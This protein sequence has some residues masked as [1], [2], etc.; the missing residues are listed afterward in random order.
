MTRIAKLLNTLLLLIFVAVNANGSSTL[1]VTAPGLE[2]LALEPAAQVG[3]ISWYDATKLFEPFL[4]RVEFI[5]EEGRLNFSDGQRWGAISG[6]APYTMVDGRPLEVKHPPIFFEGKLLVSEDF[7]RDTAQAIIQRELTTSIS[8]EERGLVVVIDPAYGGSSSGPKGYKPQEAKALTLSLARSLAERLGEGGYLVLLT[9][10]GDENKSALDRATIANRREA[11]LFLRIDLIGE[12]RREARG[13]EIFYPAPPKE[14]TSPNAWRGG[15]AA[16]YEQ[17]HLWAEILERALASSLAVMDRGILPV[18]S[19]LLSA[20][21]VPAATLYVGNISWPQE[22][23]LFTNEA[24]KK[25]LVETLFRAIDEY[26]SKG[27]E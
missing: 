10:D 15:Q 25:M 22:A 16:L 23:D 9:R 5:P 17:S 26:L 1:T 14:G 8:R 18:S 12:E 11:D 24:D 7:I 27:R 4:E 13:F 2:P 19:P 21:N 20:L 6:E 3:G